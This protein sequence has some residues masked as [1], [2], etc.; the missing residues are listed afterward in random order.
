MKRL[1]QVFL[2]RALNQLRSINRTLIIIIFMGSIDRQQRLS[3]TKEQPSP[4]SSL[5]VPHHYFAHE[6]AAPLA[7][8]QNI[9]NCLVTPSD[10]LC[11]PHIIGLSL[12]TL[13]QLHAG[14]PQVN[15]HYPP[16]RVIMGIQSNEGLAFL[17]TYPSSV[18]SYFPSYALPVSQ[19]QCQQLAINMLPINTENSQ[20]RGTTVEDFHMNGQPPATMDTLLTN[21]ISYRQQNSSFFPQLNLMGIVTGG[22]PVSTVASLP[23]A[24]IL[25]QNRLGSIARNSNMVKMLPVATKD[26]AFAGSGLHDDLEHHSCYPDNIASA[27]SFT[28]AI[29]EVTSPHPHLSPQLQVGNNCEQETQAIRSSKSKDMVCRDASYLLDPL[30]PGKGQIVSRGGV[31]ELF[32]ERLHR[33]LS[34]VKEEG[35]ADI[36]GFFAHGRALCVFKPDIFVSRIMPRYFK[37]RKLSSFQRQLNLYGFTRINGGPDVRGYYHELFLRERPALSR[38][39]RRSQHVKSPE[40]SRKGPIPSTNQHV[41]GVRI[42]DF[43]KMDP[44]LSNEEASSRQEELK[45]NSI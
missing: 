23:V 34:E 27:S 3:H 2:S 35:K 18:N 40:T 32:P 8:E 24:S 21:K 1:I 10:R 4:M 17:Q 20:A 42:P 16:H 7:R 22:V 19:P 13:I 9:N 15:D 38:K 28:G 11:K 25:S 36:V 39:M 44:I 43:Y 31:T 12:P 41:G 33:M 37:Q 26:P 45:K 6:R 29:N 14:Q 5:P 30:P